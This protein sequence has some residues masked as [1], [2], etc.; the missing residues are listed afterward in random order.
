MYYLLSSKPQCYEL[1]LSVTHNLSTLD[2]EQSEERNDYTM[3]FI[4]FFC[5]HLFLSKSAPIIKLE[6][7]FSFRE[8]GTD[9]TLFKGFFETTKR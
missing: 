6:K 8:S 3:V 4:S 1:N 9:G 2:P 5:K 7:W